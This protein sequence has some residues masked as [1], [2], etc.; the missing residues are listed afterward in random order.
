MLV[1]DYPEEAA[2]IWREFIWK[3]SGSSYP[4][5]EVHQ[6]STCGRKPV[7]SVREQRFSEYPLSL[8]GGFGGSFWVQFISYGH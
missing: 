2:A 7:S 8:C 3:L 4:V 6:V 5:S 1:P